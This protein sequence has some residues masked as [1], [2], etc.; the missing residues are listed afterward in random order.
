MSAER[1]RRGPLDGVEGLPRL[2]RVRLERVSRA[3][4]L[5]HD[6]ADRVRHDVVELAGD[7]RAL[8]RDG[9]ARLLLALDDELALAAAPA[10]HRAPGEPEARRRW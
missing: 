8:L 7:A 9:R 1:D 3:A 5:Q 4:R 2:G 10:P 6:D